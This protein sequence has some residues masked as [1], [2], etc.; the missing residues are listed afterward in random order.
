MIIDALNVSPPASKGSVWKVLDTNYKTEY[1]M[2]SN[3]RFALPVGL[4]G[5]KSKEREKEEKAAE[6]TAITRTL[7]SLQ[8]SAREAFRT[9]VCVSFVN[10]NEWEKQ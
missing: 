4:G 5:G 6:A 8:N 3:V 1:S 9:I 2:L 7:V 10:W